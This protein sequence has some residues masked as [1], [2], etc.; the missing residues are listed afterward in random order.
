[1]Q[2]RF[3]CTLL[4]VDRRHNEG[5]YLEGTGCDRSIGGHRTGHTE[6]T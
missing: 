2:M 1:M 4:H 3:Y 5:T 6:G